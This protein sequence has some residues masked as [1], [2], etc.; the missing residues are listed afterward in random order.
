MDI[1]IGSSVMS[2]PKEEKQEPLYLLQE[3]NMV[4]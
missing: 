2:S 4:T 1:L 3:D